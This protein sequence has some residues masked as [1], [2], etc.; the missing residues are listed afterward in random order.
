MS[1]PDMRT[2]IS[3]YA[4][5]NFICMIVMAIQWRQNRKR[6]NGLGKQ[7]ATEHL[8]TA[9]GTP[10]IYRYRWD[11]LGRVSG[12]VDPAG[13]TRGQTNNLLDQVV[14]VDDPDR[15]VHIDYDPNRPGCCIQA[16][17]VCQ[18]VITGQVDALG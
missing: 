16:G 8:L 11:E 5:S 18:F 15:G 14:S 9:G 7:I 3:S 17:Q 6:F 1:L 12:L 10:Q 2:V 4:I 13:N